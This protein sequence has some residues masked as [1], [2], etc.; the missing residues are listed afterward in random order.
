MN[1]TTYVP[2]RG[3]FHGGKVSRMAYASLNILKPAEKFRGVANFY[4]LSLGAIRII[5]VKVLQWQHNMRN[6]QNFSP[7]EH[8][9]FMVYLVLYL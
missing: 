4:N 5:I 3:M 6:T 1:Q 9:P 8:A 2:K 7:L